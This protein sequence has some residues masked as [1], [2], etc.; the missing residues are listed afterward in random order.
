MKGTGKLFVS[1][2]IERMSRCILDYSS[3]SAEKPKMSADLCQFV[4]MTKTPSNTGA[5]LTLNG[6]TSYGDV[7][8]L[9]TVFAKIDLLGVTGAYGDATALIRDSALLTMFQAAG[10]VTFNTS[11]LVG[12]SNLV[13]NNCPKGISGDFANLAETNS[14]QLYIPDTATGIEGSIEEFVARKLQLHPSTAGS[15]SLNYSG[16]KLPNVYED[17][18]RT[19]PISRLNKNTVNFAWDEN[20]TITITTPN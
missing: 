16:K 6:S 14:S 10:D 20:G 3:A 19:L 18:A 17:A 1:G 5:D 7:S 11:A 8:K 15:F 4:Y 13:C 12:K 9:P 2:R